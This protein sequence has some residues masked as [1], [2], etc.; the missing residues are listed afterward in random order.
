M[1]DD[2][3]LVRE[4]TATNS[5]PAFATLV[6]RH[7]GLVHSSALR[8][9]GDAH[10]AEEI[11]Q[12]VFI[13]LARKAASL[14]PKTVLAAWLYRT[15]RYAA[16]DALRTRRRR[17]SRE[18]EAFMQSTLNQPDNE[19]WTQ[20]APLLD[21]AM[22]ELGE[23]DRTALVLRYFENKSAREIA[24]A[25]RMVESTAQKRVARALEKLRARFVKRGV[26]LTATVIA[27]A[28][29][30]NSVQAAPVG[31][32][33]T[34]M[35]T[36]AKG[37]VIGSSTLTLIK[38]ALK[39]MAWTKIQ[40]TVVTSVVVL[41]AAGTTITVKEIQERKTYSWQV[42]K[43]DYDILYKT[44]PE[45]R[46]V[47]TKFNADGGVVADGSRGVIGIAQ[48]VK[49]I[50]QH[51]YQKYD[52][53]TVIRTDMPAGRYDFIAKITNLPA[54]NTNWTTALQNEIS[55][56]FGLIGR[57]EMIETNVLVLKVAN[58]NV[59][60]FKAA[61]SLRQSFRQTNSS[62]SSLAIM[63]GPG[64]FAVFDQ[65]ISTLL[66]LIEGRFKIPV[67]DQTG[68]SAHYDYHLQWDEKDRDHLNSTGLQ[69][70]LLDQLGLELVPTNMPIEMLVIEKVK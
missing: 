5:E 32:A 27:S 13:I 40:T 28:V 64:L 12:A 46:I 65:S 29:A 62:S 47:A 38:G 63:S 19:T 35:A 67:I 69:Q 55:R 18:Q 51:A 68:L 25:L 41:L 42:P 58:G 8:Q 4:F 22:A 45:V 20:L 53:R 36:A 23:T 54:I 34:V 33:V 57:Y 49:V 7:I 70:A 2:I 48:P 3:T 9:V 44:Q 6:E 50:V 10:L 52:L 14:G 26:T 31:L 66:P 16:A 60:G 11:T 61:N 59:A 21:D 30:A 39:L 37:A 15:T 1:D 17:Q 43:A 24:A 56:K